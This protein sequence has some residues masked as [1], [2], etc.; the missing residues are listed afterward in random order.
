MK[1][2][3]FKPD[4]FTE[5]EFRPYVTAIGQ[6]ALAWN[7]LHERL[8]LL[9]CSIMGGGWIDRPMGVWF[10]SQFDRPRRA[11]LRSAA[12]TAT[13]DEIGRHP[14]L[15]DDLVWVIT[16][17]DK[18]EDERN[19]MVHAPLYR[20]RPAR[21]MFGLSGVMP[22]T[23]LGNTRAK[24]LDKSDILFE[25]RRIRDTA[26]V[27]RDFASAMDVALTRERVPWPERPS[28]PA[29]A[30]ETKS[31]TRPRQGKKQSRP[32]PPRSSPA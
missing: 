20:V 11:M 27:L 4:R 24:R 8:A 10:S 13:G 1:S 29:R 31:R 23:M 26:L 17:T 32:P 5:P 28:L 16:Q 2:R 9:F 14:T 15:V 22:N 21:Y 3:T 6:A 25:F 30:P 18:L 7:D 19:N 12:E